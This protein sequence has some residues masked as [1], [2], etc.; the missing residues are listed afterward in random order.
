MV[1]FFILAKLDIAD[2]VNRVNTWW[3]K[4]YR[5]TDLSADLRLPGRDLQPESV[6]PFTNES[7]YAHS[8]AVG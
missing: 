7:P 1:A 3:L 8:D 2:I 6:C 5:F 4:S